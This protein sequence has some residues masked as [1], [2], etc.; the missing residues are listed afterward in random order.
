MR[1]LPGNFAEL[2]L[3]GLCESY[4]REQGVN[5]SAKCVCLVGVESAAH[6]AAAAMG[7]IDFLLKLLQP[8]TYLPS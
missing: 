3:G 7:V 4:R 1:N 2:H 6:P 5:A 8:V